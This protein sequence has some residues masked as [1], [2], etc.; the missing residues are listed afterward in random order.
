SKGGRGTPDRAPYDAPA[1]GSSSTLS[2]RP[3][4]GPTW[5]LGRKRLCDCIYV[6]PSPFPHVSAHSSY[7]QDSPRL[8]FLGE[9][10]PGNRHDSSA[11]S[12]GRTEFKNSPGRDRFS[13]FRGGR[14]ELALSSEPHAS[15]TDD[16][17][18]R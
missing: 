15:S 13:A 14:T 18:A 16:R 8:Q 6:C 12:P 1:G 7:D 10:V 17:A 5:R 9:G 3:S 11:Q 2:D 4:G